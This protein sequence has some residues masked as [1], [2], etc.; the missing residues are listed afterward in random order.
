MTTQGISQSVDIFQLVREVPFPDV[1]QAFN[2][3][4]VKRGKIFCPFHDEKTPSFHIY[5]DGYKCFGCGEYGDSANFVAR[6][7]RVS[8]FEAARLITQKLDLPFN[9]PQ[10]LEE[11][12]SLKEKTSKINMGK[13]Y[14]RLE[15]KAFL[16]MANFRSLV[17]NI[18]A[19]V[20][21]D[22]LE[23]DTLRAINL[24]PQIEDNIRILTTGSSEERL[25]LLREGELSRWA[26]IK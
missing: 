21:F 6:L 20:D 18:M 4:K 15:E 12:Q 9:R 11:E 1:Q 14:E 13:L 8:N 3:Q 10:T 19:V 17:L 7:E 26:K 2:G 23:P 25:S 16:K 24:L 5:D 22:E